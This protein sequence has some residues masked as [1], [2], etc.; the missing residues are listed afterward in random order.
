MSGYD[1]QID[2]AETNSPSSTNENTLQVET[3]IGERVQE[4]L[5]GWDR[6][7]AYLIMGSII[8]AICGLIL[9]LMFMGV[10]IKY[11]PSSTMANTATATYIAPIVLR[12]Y[13]RSGS[14]V[15]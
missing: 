2:V 4:K 12:T 3:T 8:F 1:R 7:R 9:G 5:H 6:F 10:L 14:W 11:P 13:C 15:A